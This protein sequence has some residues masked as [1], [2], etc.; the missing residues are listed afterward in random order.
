MSNMQ[1]ALLDTQVRD[2]DLLARLSGAGPM[3]DIIFRQCATEQARRDTLNSLSPVKRKRAIVTH[4][5]AENVGTTRD[6]LRHVHSV[7]AICS[8]PYNRLPAHERQWN[9]QPVSYT[10]LDY[11]GPTLFKWLATAPFKTRAATV[12]TTSA[13]LLKY[14]A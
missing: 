14:A 11:S 10:H 7:L 9:A 2:P 8:L 1:P 6:N 12:R 5:I 4:A 3:H 13:P